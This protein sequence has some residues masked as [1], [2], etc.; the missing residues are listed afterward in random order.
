M[1]G[2]GTECLRVVVVWL[3][4]V[5]CWDMLGRLREGGEGEGRRERVR[6]ISIARLASVGTCWV[7]SEKVRRGRERESV[8]IVIV[9]AVS[10]PMRR[11]CWLPLGVFGHTAWRETWRKRK[12]FKLGE[13]TCASS[14]SCRCPWRQSASRHCRRCRCRVDVVSLFMSL[15]MLPVVATPSPSHSSTVRI[16]R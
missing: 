15:S 4:S 12:N 5:Q 8:R 7:D 2:T 11:R 9:A 16:G 14:M 13:G 1:T 6:V 10:A 3:A